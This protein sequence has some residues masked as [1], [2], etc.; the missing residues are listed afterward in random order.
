M[1]DVCIFA[2]FDGDDL[3]DPHVLHYLGQLKA[4]GFAIVF[5]T[6]SAID[7]NEQARVMAHCVDCIVRE[8]VGHDFGS[9]SAGLARWRDRIEGRLLLAN[10][11]VYGPLLPLGPQLD[12]LTSVK[13]DFYGMVLN[14][15]VR[16]HLQ[17]WFL[18]FEPQVVASAA[19]GELFCQPVKPRS[20]TSVIEELELTATARLAEAG[21]TYHA[22]HMPGERA[23]IG[24][25]TVYLWRELI[26]R[27]AVPFLKVGVL[28]LD[29]IGLF[30]DG[31]WRDVIGGLDAASLA[32]IDAHRARLA[33]DKPPPPP[34][35]AR[36]RRRGYRRLVQI[37]D[38]IAR[39]GSAPLIG[40]NRLALRALLPLIGGEQR[41]LAP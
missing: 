7:G 40:M 1:R 36:L 27:D 37:D 21:F 12:R 10:D 24:N 13:A 41:R 16:P 39:S 4:C 25:P 6:A 3:V 17:S 23:L 20:R 22:L 31:R 30:A 2:H 28:Q 14:R 29:P 32:R 35:L 19:F 33:G 15:E 34:L 26:E 8:N 5:V 11:S 9:W 38:A 18:L